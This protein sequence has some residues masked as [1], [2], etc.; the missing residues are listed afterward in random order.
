MRFVVAVGL[1]VAAA[2]QPT[3]TPPAPLT[4]PAADVTTLAS[5]AFLGR[6]AGTPGADSAAA[7]IVR[8]YTDLKLRPAFRAGCDSAPQCGRTYRQVFPFENGVAQNVGAI[9][10]GTD[11][12]LRAEYI[13][14]GAH[15]DHLGQSPRFAFDPD[16]RSEMRPGADDNASG[17]AGVLELARRFA[18]RPI[19]RSVMLLN[20]DAEEQ[21]L[22]GSREFLTHPPIP[23]RAIVLMLN[24]D[25]IGRMRGDHV[26]VEG[27]ADHFWSRSMIERA[28][29]A[30]VRIE[31]IPDRGNSDHSSF[32]AQGVSVVSLST[33]EH[34][35]YH[36]TS[37]IAARIN[38]RGLERVIDFAE[39]IV[40]QQ[41]AR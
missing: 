7:F 20:F 24:L 17:T 14:I 10:E 11:A 21:G 36:K 30:R 31:F 25:M 27:V 12:R 4:G 6:R 13:V 38:Y 9:I 1:V 33:G 23:K 32:A 3:T 28:A 15:F 19:R 8:R 26:L 40:R 37:D 16:R 18:E 29:G 5:R 2:C 22:L 34:F 41:D 39:G 35:D